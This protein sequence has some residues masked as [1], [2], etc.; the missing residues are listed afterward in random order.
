[1]L[2]G[3]KSGFLLGV[4]QIYERRRLHR[5]CLSKSSCYNCSEPAMTFLACTVHQCNTVSI[6]V[7]MTYLIQDLIIIRNAFCIKMS[8]EPITIFRMHIPSGWILRRPL[9]QTV[10]TASVQAHPFVANTPAHLEC[11]SITLPAMNS[12]NLVF[13][14]IDSCVL[15]RAYSGRSSQPQ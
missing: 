9:S 13:L 7:Y 3:T 12:S 10:W 14:F 1:M 4:F 5:Y 15:N 2:Q 8:L 11:F 6:T